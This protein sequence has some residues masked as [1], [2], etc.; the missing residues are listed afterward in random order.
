M[1]NNVAVLVEKS[2]ISTQLKQHP[3]KYLDFFSVVVSLKTTIFAY[4]KVCFL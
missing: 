4:Q 3:T 2:N 1:D